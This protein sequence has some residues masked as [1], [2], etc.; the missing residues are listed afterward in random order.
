LHGPI[1]AANLAGLTAHFP[2]LRS[3]AYKPDAP[4]RIPDL[5]ILAL[6]GFV[7]G[8]P[9]GQRVAIMRDRT[10]ADVLIDGPERTKR[11]DLSG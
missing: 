5:H 2:G 7:A 4:D 6:H 1:L 8:G 11:P 9:T 3:L 10:A